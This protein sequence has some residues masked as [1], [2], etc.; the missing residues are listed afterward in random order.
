VIRV[1]VA[2]EAEPFL[3]ATDVP[4]DLA[5]ELLPPGAPIPAGEYAGILPLLTRRIGPEEMDRLAGLRVVANLA[6]GYDNVDLLPHLGSATRE[7][8]QGMFDLAFA[9]LVRG[10]RGVELLTP[11]G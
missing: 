4:G 5:V 6:V 8:R 3:Q 11:V 10:V 9:N 2:G 1:L 7:A